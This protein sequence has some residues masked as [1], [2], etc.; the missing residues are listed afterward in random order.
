MGLHLLNMV[1]KTV[2]TCLLIP[3]Q[4]LPIWILE[5]CLT[6]MDG[7]GFAPTAEGGSDCDDDNAN[8]NPNAEEMCND[9]IDNIMMDIQ[10]LWQIV[11]KM[12]IRI[13]MTVMTQMRPK[14][15]LLGSIVTMTVIL[16]EIVKK[17]NMLVALLKDLLQMQM[18]VMMKNQPSIIRL[19]LIMMVLIHVTIAMMN[20]PSINADATEIWY[21]GVDQNC[22]TLNDYDQDGDGASSID[23]DGTDCDD[24][25]VAF[26][27][28]AVD[29][30]DDGIDQNCDGSDRV[31]SYTSGNY[32]IHNQNDADGICSSNYS[33]MFKAFISIWDKKVLT[34]LCEL[35]TKIY[36][37]RNK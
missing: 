33:H 13:V 5:N 17:W 10:L 9:G 30:C 21:D 1:V 15:L 2:M 34:F 11:M 18:I 7:D 32:Y 6:D 25:D 22:D 37:Y 3:T 28:D 36:I 14:Q 35:C 24:T 16:S 27:P 29:I 26:G 8:V 23:H 12:A 4:D 20:D 19:M 31:C